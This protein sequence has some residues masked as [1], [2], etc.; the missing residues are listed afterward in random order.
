M[1]A[2]LDA[3]RGFH[4]RRGSKTFVLADASR[5]FYSRIYGTSNNSITQWSQRGRSNLRLALTQTIMLQYNH[6]LH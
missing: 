4:T 2:A 1:R 5:G 3:S 6:V